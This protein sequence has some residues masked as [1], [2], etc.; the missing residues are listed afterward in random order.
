MIIY[1]EVVSLKKIGGGGGG[2][3]VVTWV[4]QAQMIA[5]NNI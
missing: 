1:I 3:G 2:G 5:E 4:M